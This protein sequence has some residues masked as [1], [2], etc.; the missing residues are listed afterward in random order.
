MSIWIIIMFI[1]VGYIG[2]LNGRI[3]GY[4]KGFSEAKE[5][6]DKSSELLEKGIQIENRIVE[7]A[8]ETNV[9]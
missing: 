9:K 7:G 3:T 4:I 1:V 2:Y 8:I 6:Y 5:K